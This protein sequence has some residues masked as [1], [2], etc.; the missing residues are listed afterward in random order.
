MIYNLGMPGNTHVEK[1]K[2]L[3]TLPVEQATYYATMAHAFEQHTA[4]LIAYASMGHWTPERDDEIRR[5]LGLPET[6]K[7]NH[8][9]AD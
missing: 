9:S 5:R 2:E 1:L 6:E 7:E 3:G 8:D 4:N